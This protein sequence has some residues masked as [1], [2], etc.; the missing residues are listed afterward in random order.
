MT[1]I[2]LLNLENYPVIFNHD[3][4]LFSLVHQTD[5]GLRLE[6]KFIKCREYIGQAIYDKKT[7][8]TTTYNFDT[9]VSKQYSFKTG[10]TLIALNFKGLEN[11]K[12]Y[13]KKHL[14]WLHKWETQA[15]V[16]HSEILDTQHPDVLVIKG[17]GKWKD[18][19]WK[20]TLYT[21]LIKCC[22]YYRAKNCNN[23]YW[24]HLNRG[25][26]LN[27]LLSKVQTPWE[28]EI[29]SME[30]YGPMLNFNTRAKNGFL[31]ILTGQNPPMEKLLG[32]VSPKPNI[33]GYYA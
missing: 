13:L 20:I 11:R 18:S 10:N 1:T 28:E 12:A 23:D 15:G 31:T 4:V 29:F 27:I 3:G 5:Q 7:K 26:N 19:C 32:T 24:S 22:C 30:V 33:F 14:I 21:F 6:R 8:K 2:K 25:K 17:D 16:S 9:Q